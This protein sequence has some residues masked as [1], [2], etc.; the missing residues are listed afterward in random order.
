M[1]ILI[2]YESMTG[3]TKEIAMS[4]YDALKHDYLVSVKNVVDVLEDYNEYDADL[5]FLGSWTN[6]GSSGNLINEYAKTLKNKKIALFGTTGFDQSEEYFSKLTKRF[7]NNF[8]KSNSLVD[9]FHCKGRMREIVKNSYVK[10]LR[11][12]P[13]DKTLEVKIENFDEAKSHPNQKDLTNAKE[14][15]LEVVKKLV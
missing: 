5:Y 7:F 12:H 14:F 1:K 6:R 13:D 3:N 4:I 15:A 8:D 9:S 11:D 2:V 10:L